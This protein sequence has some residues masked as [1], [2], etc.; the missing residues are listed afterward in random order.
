LVLKAQYGQRFFRG[1]GAFASATES[2]HFYKNKDADKRTWDTTDFIT[3]PTYYDPVNYISREYFNVVSG[4]IFAEFGTGDTWRWQTELEYIKK[5]CKSKD[6]IDPYF[7]TLGGYQTNKYKYIQWNNFL[8]FYN[9]AGYLSHWYVLAGVRLEYLFGSSIA[10]YP[11]LDGQFPKI[12]FSGDVGAG[13]EYGLTKKW[14]LVTEY[15]WNPDVLSHKFGSARVRNRTFE[16]RV[17]IMYRPKQKSIDDC[18]APRYKG[19]AY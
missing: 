6:L 14:Y 5:G 13:Y 10:S 16:L 11:E 18:N 9:P 15:H 1:I 4:G 19:P 17:G 7:G 12:W 2:A 8:K 3:N